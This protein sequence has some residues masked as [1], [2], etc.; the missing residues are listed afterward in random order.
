M[1]QLFKEVFISMTDIFKILFVE[2]RSA[3]KGTLKK[4]R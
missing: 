3:V 2:L 4:G 1:K